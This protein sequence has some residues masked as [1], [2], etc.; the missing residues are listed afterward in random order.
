MRCNRA[1]IGALLLCLSICP[2]VTLG[3]C[4]TRSGSR[5]PVDPA[6][7]VNRFY[8]WHLGYPGNTLADK[9]YRTNT[10][11]AESFIAAVDEMLA[12]SEMGL[13][14]PFLLTQ[15]L[16]ERF[17]V[18]SRAEGVE[19]ATVLLNLYWAGSSTPVQREVALRFLEGRWQITHVTPVP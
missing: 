11:L 18:E 6:E 12:A 17:T 4:A 7:V 1:I 10:D 16:P 5:S 2:V 15:D 13:A 19:E 3:G 14:D 9:A 8:R